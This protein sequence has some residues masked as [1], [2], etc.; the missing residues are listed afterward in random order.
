M[1]LAWA[2]PFNEQR[3][4]SALALMVSHPPPVTYI[5]FTGDIAS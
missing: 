5:M 2:S 1:I 3:L 4:S